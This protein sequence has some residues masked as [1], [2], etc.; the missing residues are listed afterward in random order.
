MTPP[1]EQDDRDHTLTDFGVDT[2]LLEFFGLNEQGNVVY[3]ARKG[4]DS[5]EECVDLPSLLEKFCNV[6]D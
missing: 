5:V 2:A 6:R 3:K 4:G 1:M